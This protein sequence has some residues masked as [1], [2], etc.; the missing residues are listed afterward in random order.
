[1]DADATLRR[2][3]RT[4]IAACLVMAAAALVLARGTVWP[5]VGVIGG[6]LL[7]AVSYHTIASSVTGLVRQVA[8]GPDVE[9]I[10]RP[11]PKFAWILVKLALR[12]ALLAL[13]AY[14][15]IARLR[16]HP[17]GLMAGASSVVAAVSIEAV[18]VLLKK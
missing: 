11:R 14:V 5:A 7:I 3:E 6:G 18:R 9:A 12:Y 10:A 8:P 17:L 4:S 1:M 15:M 2:V 13:L 16:L